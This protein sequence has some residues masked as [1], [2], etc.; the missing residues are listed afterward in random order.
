MLAMVLRKLGAFELGQTPDGESAAIVFEGINLRLK[1]LHE[2]GTL[3]W[4]VGGAT[5]DV[6]LVASTVTATITPTDF[7]FPVSMALRVGTGDQPL[8]IIGH[9]AYQAI[10][11][12]A[13][14]GEPERVYING[15]TCRFY[16]VPSQSYTAKLTY[17]AIAT[18]LAASTA[19]D[20]PVSMMRAF[21]L[22]VASDLADD[23]GL[24]EQKV[25]R[26]LAQVPDAMKTL[27]A[28]NTERVDS[29][30]VTPDYF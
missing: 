8:E 5:T 11:D 4:Q 6:A 27:R 23:F 10:P 14:T 29:T 9:S 1:E 12:K 7:L 26:L 17:E 16:P 3:W 24:P 19:P 22:V 20:I 2:L 21:A 28:L 30:P 15:S 18:D 25:Q 13:S